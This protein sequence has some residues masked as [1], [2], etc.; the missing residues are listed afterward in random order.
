[1]C[2]YIYVYIYVCVYIN[3][4]YKHAFDKRPLLP[5]LSKMGGAVK[6]GGSNQPTWGYKTDH[7]RINTYIGGYIYV[8]VYLYIYMCVYIYLGAQPKKRH[9]IFP[10]RT[11]R[12]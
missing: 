10:L 4:K 2:I 5:G 6:N 7:T 11:P 8:C 3:Y 12:F 1:M 9:G